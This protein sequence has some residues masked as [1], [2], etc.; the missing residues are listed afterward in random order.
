MSKY[1]YVGMSSGPIFELMQ[2]A[3]A[4]KEHWLASYMFSRYSQHMV[5]QISEKLGAANAGYV[6]ISPSL[7]PE[8]TRKPN[9][10]AMEG[11]KR[12]LRIGL[13]SDRIFFRVDEEKDALARAVVSEAVDAAKTMLAEMIAG[14]IGR[15]VKACK[16]SVDAVVYTCSVFR[17]A[18]KIPLKEMNMALDERELFAGDRPEEGEG[19]G[20]EWELL[21]DKEKLTSNRCRWISDSAL[22]GADLEDVAGAKQKGYCDTQASNYYAVIV[23]D[24]DGVGSVLGNTCKLDAT[25]CDATVKQISEGLLKYADQASLAVLDYE[26]NAYPVYFG[27]DDME[28]FVPLYSTNKEQTFIDLI[29]QLDQIFDNIFKGNP[30]AASEKEREGIPGCERCTT[31]FG[32]NIVYFKYPLNK[33]INEAHELL[34]E[35]KS[36][37]YDKITKDTKK[38]SIKKS[39]VHIQL[40]KHSGQT[41]RI[42]L[43][44]ADSPADSGYNA[45]KAFGDYLALYDSETIIHQ[46]HHR[47]VA[48]KAILLSLV[49][50]DATVRRDR[51]VAWLENQQEETPIS[52]TYQ[53]RL[54]DLLIHLWEC[55]LWKEDPQADRSEYLKNIDGIFR[56]GE[57]MDRHAAQT[58]VKEKEE[59]AS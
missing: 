54:A 52:P 39:T 19:T 7:T 26:A 3:R 12:Q 53:E 29:G 28:A 2:Y 57:L 43:S 33:A 37:D 8:Q 22:R 30:L 34:V 18:E 44:K 27:G 59:G 31:S 45:W 10:L 5:K 35:A 11:D 20:D 21:F 17:H 25:V 23:A 56:L 40:R 41:S 36:A 9:P 58:R 14:I 48:Q 49:Q 55:R 4:T 6:L 24:G 15:P 47:L 16:S 51:I 46:I 38:S 13:Y 1:L 32:V 42:M 50:L